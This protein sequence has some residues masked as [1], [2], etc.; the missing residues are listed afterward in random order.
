MVKVMQELLTLDSLRSWTLKVKEEGNS[1]GY[2]LSTHGTPGDAYVLNRYFAQNGHPVVI[3]KYP[4]GAWYV[5]K[6]GTTRHV[7]LP[8]EFRLVIKGLAALFLDGSMGRNA[9]VTPED[10][11]SIIDRIENG[12]LR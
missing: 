1:V 8:H 12:T 11:L 3:D 6:E 4:G 5:F 10:L 7:I 2:A 9:V